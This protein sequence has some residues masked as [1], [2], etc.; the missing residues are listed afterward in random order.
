ML[1]ITKLWIMFWLLE[2]T[3]QQGADDSCSDRCRKY[4]PAKPCQ[5]DDLC[6][7]ANVE[8]CCSDYTLLCLELS[9]TCPADKHKTIAS[10]TTDRR[11]TWEPAVANYQI[12][13]P[14]GLSPI[15]IEGT[16]SPGDHFPVGSTIVYYTAIDVNGRTKNC[17]FT[18]TIEVDYCK[19]IT[20]QQNGTCV[21]GEKNFTCTCP[22][23]WGGQYCHQ[24]VEGPTI[25]SCPSTVMS[26]NE[27]GLNSSAVTWQPP[28]FTDNTGQ[29]H[30]T[31]N[32]THQPEDTFYIG[33]TKVR[34][35]AYD[36]SGNIGS[37]VFDVV[38]HD[39]EPPKVKNC[40]STP[41]TAYVKEGRNKAHVNWPT[42]VFSD[43][44]GIVNV[45]HTSNPGSVFKIGVSRVIYNATDD[46]GHV[47]TCFILIEVYDL[48]PPA[49][50]LC[51][52]NVS[53]PTATITDAHSVTWEE[54]T[55]IDNDG[56]AMETLN[57]THISGEDFF[58]WIENVKYIVEDFSGN[59]AMCS[60]TVE[61]YVGCPAIDV[62]LYSFP[63]TRSGEI[64]SSSTL[65]PFY[66]KYG[67]HPMATKSCI[68]NDES[69]EWSEG[70][71]VTDCFG[72]ENV[73]D[74][75]KRLSEITV[76]ES[77]VGEVS[78][79]V[80]GLTSGLDTISADALDSIADVLDSVVSV[81]SASVEVTS[82]VSASV[83]NILG[84]KADDGNSVGF[85]PAA[86]SKVVTSLEAQVSLAVGDGSAFDYSSE[87]LDVQA[88]N[89]GSSDFSDGLTLGVSKSGKRRRGLFRDNQ[90]QSDITITLP[91]EIGSLGGDN[92]SLNHIVYQND[93]LFVSDD[94]ENKHKTLHSS[95]A[96]AS[97]VG[98]DVKDLS[99]P[100]V[101]VFRRPK[102]D[103]V[104]RNITHCVYWNFNLRNGV[105]DWA[106]D[107]CEL[108]NVLDDGSVE[109]H[110]NHLT[111]FAVLMVCLFYKINYYLSIRHKI[112]MFNVYSF[113]I[114]YFFNRRLRVKR[115]HKILINIS[116][117][118]TCLYLTFIGSLFVN[119]IKWLCTLCAVLL[120]YFVL[121][122]LLWM[123]TEALGMYYNLIKV[124][125]SHISHFLLKACL[126]S[127]G[128][129]AII[130]GVI[131]AIDRGQYVNNSYCFL[132][133]GYGLYFGLL[134]MIAII[135]LFNFVV[136]VLVMKELFG[137]RMKPSSQ[138]TE[139][140]KQTNKTIRKLQ[141]A[142]A[143]SI[144]LG[145]TWAFGFLS[146]ASPASI[147]FEVLFCIFNSF[148][149][150]IIFIFFCLRNQ[151]IRNTWKAK[152]LY[153][154]DRYL[155][156]AF[157]S[158]QRTKQSVIQK[159]DTTI[160]DNSTSQNFRRSSIV[161]LD[162]VSDAIKATK[163]NNNC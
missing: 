75:L 3:L 86:A 14:A 111:N 62:G 156:S 160:T 43:N 38:I 44:S 143:V 40:T 155:N 139:K 68:G 22:K 7:S 55:A 163:Q 79:L 93:K 84:A 80:E 31:M 119:K 77:N 70:E 28:V 17:S 59:K 140:G 33:S 71:I 109:C 133:P 157:H 132:I 103:L 6:A 8:D 113:K 10:G 125:N 11:V 150:L 36:L 108:V 78:T 50:T 107:G 135:L 126:V 88:F 110:C 35:D 73:D 121:S 99:E 69:A 9:I 82:S 122:S 161:E 95:V 153:G 47:T 56:I 114:Y 76:D 23:G 152:I 124:F 46:A 34:Y 20:C 127:W 137:A 105:G 74:Q 49:F 21:S 162:K 57:S 104:T 146:M 81:G 141:N 120:H 54:P 94:D 4:D 144:L 97:V 13:T 87:E 52:P 131:L 25:I 106:E 45:H 66:A 128:T 148:Q 134:M 63:N 159:Y 136:Y 100:V 154:S 48:I 30:I 60:F 91:A 118:L 12:A 112:H 149:G 115:H 18:V 2:T 37:C 29:Q 64:A 142:F 15:T 158:S 85:P 51:P 41:I 53:L 117:S 101:I 98:V 24:D 145:L 61:V 102:T 90:H 58:V 19:N 138:A 67:G 26:N 116:I 89:V 1:L 130:I 147:V 123:A 42:P 129:P 151:E 72:E 39:S 65:C 32:S 27:P 92:L 16:M 83:G 5:C 96:S